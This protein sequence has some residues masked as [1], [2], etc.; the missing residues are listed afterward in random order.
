MVWGIEKFFDQKQCYKYFKK[1][2]SIEGKPIEDKLTHLCKMRN[3]PF[4]I[5]KLSQ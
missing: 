2:F 5:V 4:F 1:N 3:K